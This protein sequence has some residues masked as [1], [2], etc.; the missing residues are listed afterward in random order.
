[1]A[2][3]WIGG[4]RMSNSAT[5]DQYFKVPAGGTITPTFPGMLAGP[6]EIKG[7]EASTYN[8][9]APGSPNMSFYTTQRALFGASFEEIAGFGVGR[10]APVYHF[11][12]YDQKSPGSTNWVLIANPGRGEAKA[13]VWIAGVKKTT[14]SIAPGTSQTPTFP[15][16]MNGP[17]EVR[18]YDSATYNPD[19]PGVPNY[20]IF[21]SQRVL[22]N[23][24]FNEVEGIVL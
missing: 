18:G 6:V 4:Q 11:S 16:I 8:P 22:W 14:L 1:V 21:V 24:H 12:W 17:V 7:Y 2:E 3:V 19:N 9:A 15:D 13:E 20:N 23:G 10:L 5:G